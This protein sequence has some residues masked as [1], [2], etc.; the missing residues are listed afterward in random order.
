[1]GPKKAAA[2]NAKKKGG[3]ANENGGEMVSLHIMQMILLSSWKVKLLR[4]SP[5]GCRNYC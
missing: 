4:L 3:D 5:L 2:K 1:M